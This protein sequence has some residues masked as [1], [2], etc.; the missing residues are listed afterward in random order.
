MNFTVLEFRNIIIPCFQSSYSDWSLLELMCV[1][2]VKKKKK[3]T[4]ENCK[5]F[6]ENYRVRLYQGTQYKLT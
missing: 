5:I 6:Y 4:R 3:Q 2:G 1:F